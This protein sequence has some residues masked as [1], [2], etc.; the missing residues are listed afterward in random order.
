MSHTT[1]YAT[2]APYDGFIIHDF[3]DQAA[4][5]QI[6]TSDN[7]LVGQSPFKLM[8]YAKYKGGTTGYYTFAGDP[9]KISITLTADCSSPT[10]A[11]PA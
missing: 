7:S 10:I 5:L 4:P 8:V 3:D 1:T 6:A 2:P 11:V 9:I